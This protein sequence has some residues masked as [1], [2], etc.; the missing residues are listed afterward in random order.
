MNKYWNNKKMK[1]GGKR[2]KNECGKQKR[3]GQTIRKKKTEVD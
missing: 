3:N 1:T 2:N